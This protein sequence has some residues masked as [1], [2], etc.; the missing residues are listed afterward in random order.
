ML[1]HSGVGGFKLQSS[2]STTHQEGGEKATR[3]AYALFSN[4]R[5]PEIPRGWIGLARKFPGWWRVEGGWRVGS[6]L[7]PLP[8]LLLLLLLLRVPGE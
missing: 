3:G 6:M 4:R 5:R 1:L 8:L 7:L 2:G